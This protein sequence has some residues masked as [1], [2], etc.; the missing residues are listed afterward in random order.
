ME[1][2]DLKSR[3]FLQSV[4][5]DSLLLDAETGEL[6]SLN[7]EAQLVIKVL[8][9]SPSME[10]AFSQVAELMKVSLPEAV[11]ISSTLLSHLL[12]FVPLE[13]ARWTGDFSFVEKADCWEL[14]LEKSA[15]VNIEKEDFVIRWLAGPLEGQMSFAYRALLA[16]AP[17]LLS[18]RGHFVVHASAFQV[19]GETVMAVGHSGAG[20]TT[21]ARAFQSQ[22]ARLVS[23]DLC[24]VQGLRSANKESQPLVA[25]TFESQVREWA[26]AAATHLAADHHSYLEF[27]VLSTD[28]WEPLS[29]IWHISAQRRSDREEF[30]FRQLAPLEA[31]TELF[32]NLFIGTSQPPTLIGA[33]RSACHLA[34]NCRSAALDSPSNLDSLQAAIRNY[35]SKTAS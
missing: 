31:A 35:R 25:S 10:A 27:P 5:L 21:L 30:G 9:S 14:T 32:Q 29:W 7:D 13:R 33:F 16:V 19:E 28:S 12:D 8:L 15:I 18:A 22:G 2:K 6:F 11:G 20:K 4:A 3:F 17:K 1:I 34:A 23:E 24:V 26:R